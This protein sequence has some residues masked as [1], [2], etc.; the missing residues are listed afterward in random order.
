LCSLH[1]SKKNQFYQNKMSDNE[2]EEQWYEIALQEFTCYVNAQLLHVSEDSAENRLQLVLKEFE[3]T[4]NLAVELHD[5]L[6]SPN[7]LEFTKQVSACNQPLFYQFTGLVQETTL[8]GDKMYF[9]FVLD[10]EMITRLE[11]VPRKWMTLTMS[12]IWALIGTVSLKVLL[13]DN[14]HHH[15]SNII[16]SFVHS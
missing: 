15:G 7:I 1:S 16:T 8:D 2:E 12:L 11:E 4:D 5:I 14:H 10:D 9:R 6:P 13:F 3:G